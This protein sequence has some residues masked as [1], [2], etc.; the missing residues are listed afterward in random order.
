MKTWKQFLEGRD[1]FKATGVPH[2][3]ADDYQ[4]SPRLSSHVPGEAEYQGW[5]RSRINKSKFGYA[6]GKRFAAIPGRFIAKRFGDWA[7]GIVHVVGG[8]NFSYEM[9]SLP[10]KRFTANVRSIPYLIQIIEDEE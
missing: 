8:S 5:L 4:P 3:A 10:G 6:A 9:D 1:D 2:Y 7:K